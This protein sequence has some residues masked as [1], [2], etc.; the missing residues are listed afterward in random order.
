MLFPNISIWGFS[1]LL[2]CCPL[3]LISLGWDELGGGE[4]SNGVGLMK[5]GP[6]LYFL[7]AIEPVPVPLIYLL[8]SLSWTMIFI[9]T[10]ANNYSVDFGISS[11]RISFLRL[12][13]EE[14]FGGCTVLCPSFFLIPFFIVG[15]FFILWGCGTR[16]FFVTLLC[17][18]FY[19]PYSVLLD[20]SLRLC[21]SEI[22]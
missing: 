20:I 19:C 9:D 22:K 6:F 4:G 21:M 12:T 18:Y 11:G 10:P 5:R 13:L 2:Y 7:L 17:L 3:T 1:L 15:Y 8:Q 14:V 16:F